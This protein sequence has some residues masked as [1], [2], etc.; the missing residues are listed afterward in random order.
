MPERD[1]LRAEALLK[2][3]R[4]ATATLLGGRAAFTHH[5]GSRRMFLRAMR[6]AL[7]YHYL[8]GPEYRQRCREQG[9]APSDLRGVEDL[10]R[11]P[12]TQ[13]GEVF[14]SVP[15]ER[16][17]RTLD[18]LPFDGISLRRLRKL[19]RH[20]FGA[21]GLV[22]SRRT[23]YIDGP[24][25]EFL[26][27]LTRVQQV[28]S[29]AEALDRYSETRYPLRVLGPVR[30][31][32]P[33]HRFGPLS[34]VLSP[35]PD[36]QLAD[37]LGIPPQNVRRL[38]WEMAHGVPYAACEAG[39]LHIPRYSRVSARSDGRL[40]FLTPWPHSF[41]SISWLS[42]RCGEILHGCPCGRTAPILRLL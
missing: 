37:W 40:H 18:G 1:L 12:A 35:Q 28:A 21:L 7:A 30:A 33:P 2:R 3:T 32:G 4:G 27:R 29:D 20:V 36:S 22:D 6:E 42:Q 34:Y 17:V 10:D 24:H 39:Q 38:F 19:V 31:E 23:N 15:P 8:N 11:I 9:F 13:E 14:L 41:A 25:S 16:V 5:A 26:T